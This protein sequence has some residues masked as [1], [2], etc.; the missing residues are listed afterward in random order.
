M[1]NKIDFIHTQTAIENIL[2][3]SQS[4]GDLLQKYDTSFFINY[5]DK[6]TIEELEEKLK[7]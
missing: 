1:D 7:G 3:Y 4:H 2:A 5:F 6:F